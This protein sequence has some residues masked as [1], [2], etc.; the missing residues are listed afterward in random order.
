MSLQQVLLELFGDAAGQM[1][2]GQDAVRE[3]QQLLVD[4]DGGNIVAVDQQAAPQAEEGRRAVRKTLGNKFLEVGKTRQ[5]TTHT[6]V[7]IVEVAIV[8]T[9]LEVDHAVEVYEPQ[10]VP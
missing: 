3:G 7:D 1:E 2:W 5:L 4:I 9:G 8:T 6:A 10:F